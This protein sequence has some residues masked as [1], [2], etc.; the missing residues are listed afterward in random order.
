M[1]TTVRNLL[2]AILA[3][4]LL[5]GTAFGDP[6]KGG[7]GTG[8]W[9]QL[10]GSNGQSN[11]AGAGGYR[12]VYRVKK[13]DHGLTLRLARSMQGAWCIVDCG[14][15]A[16]ALLGSNEGMIHFPG[17]QLRTIK[18]AGFVEVDLTIVAPNED[19]LVG[20][21]L[22]DEQDGLTLKIR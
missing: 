11:G 17:M 6:N 1:L 21:I 8:G 7:D 22:F 2:A 3:G 14:G 20:K 12:V 9:I 18:D 19:V 16:N 10:P 15:G 5:L 4:V 13:L